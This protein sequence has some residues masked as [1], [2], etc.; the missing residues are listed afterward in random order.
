M[1]KIG[2]SARVLGRLLGPLL[3][4]GFSLIGNVLK[5]LNLAKR[6]TLIITNEEMNDIMKIMKSLKESGWLIKAI[7]KQLKTKQN[8]KREGFSVCC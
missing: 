8:N 1:H 2:Q 6:T 7:A 4:T 3:K 5:P